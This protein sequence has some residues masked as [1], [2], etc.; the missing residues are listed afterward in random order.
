MPTPRITTGMPRPSP[1]GPVAREARVIGEGGK[2]SRGAI[3]R[4]RASRRSGG[5]CRRT[6]LFEDVASEP[7]RVLRELEIHSIVLG[8]HGGDLGDDDGEILALERLPAR[9]PEL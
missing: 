9:L 4:E 5:S 6:F 7:G 3:R 8:T 1:T 2:V